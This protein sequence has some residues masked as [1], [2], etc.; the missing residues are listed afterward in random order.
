MSKLHTVEDPTDWLNT[1]LSSFEPLEAALRCQVCKEF[2][3]TPMITTCSHTFCSLCIRRCFNSDGKCPTCRAS[4]QADKLRR[5][6]VVQELVDTFKAARP[7]ALKLAQA[8]AGTEDEETE[9]AKRKRKLDQTDIEEDDIGETRRPRRTRRSRSAVDGISQ[10][11]PIEVDDSGDEDYDPEEGT[12]LC[13]ICKSRMKVGLVYA[14]LDQCDGKPVNNNGAGRSR[15]QPS[16]PKEPPPSAARLPQFNYSLLKDN[17]LKK[18][19]Q[20]LGI[21]AHG[22]RALLI[23]RH[24]EWVNLWNSNCDST[25][26]KTKRELLRELDTWERSQGAGAS[27]VPS[28]VMRKDFDGQGWAASNKDQFEE[29]I[30]NARRNRTRKEAKV[31][32]TGEKPS[33]AQTDSTPTQQPEPAPS[34]EALVRQDEISKPYEGNEEALSIV[35]EK[36]EETNTHGRRLRSSGQPIPERPRDD[37]VPMRTDEGTSLDGGVEANPPISSQHQSPQFV[38]ISPNVDM[39]RKAH[40]FRLP[41]DPIVD[42]DGGRSVS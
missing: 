41:E 26:P 2:Y 29:L 31:E 32:K 17:A 5:N 37:E 14:H 10:E 23:R 38:P 25:R 30:A 1:S 34:I 19:L 15:V 8:K 9:R 35:R 16:K 40:M 7:A 11:E 28:A 13:P 21:A 20:D 39:S 27:T 22:S 18:K 24:T 6:W 3:D 12:T 42:T 36:V 33:E 4:D